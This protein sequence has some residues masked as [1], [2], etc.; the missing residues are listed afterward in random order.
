MARVWAA[1]AGW[2]R[3]AGA[4]IAPYVA[5]A[6]LMPAAFAIAPLLYWRN[7]KRS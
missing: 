1:V 4:A 2:R 7:R 5:L 6:V 3:G